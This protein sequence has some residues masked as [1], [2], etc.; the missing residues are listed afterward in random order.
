MLQ[1]VKIVA[2]AVSLGLDC[3]A[4]AAGVGLTGPALAVRWRIVGTFGIAQ[5]LLLLAGYEL[6][7]A[8]GGVA[9]SLAA[10]AAV[11]ILLVLAVYTIAQSRRPN[12]AGQH[13]LAG[14][15]GLWLAAGS[16]SVDALAVGFSLSVFAVPPLRAF[17]IILP[18][19]F[20]M[21]GVGLEFGRQLGARIEALADAA[22][23]AVLA[24]VGL[25]MLA[26][27]ILH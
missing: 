18:A 25:V 17:A 8:V 11:V 7:A 22:A 3:L 13:P 6:G 12:P 4:V 20:L 16:V 1:T 23:G 27:L 14:G 9:G 5:A 15:W 2:L 21:T 26:E 24:L 10:Y 19:G